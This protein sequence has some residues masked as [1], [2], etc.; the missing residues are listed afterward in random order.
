MTISDLFDQARKA[1]ARAATSSPEPATS[2]PQTEIEGAAR[3]GRVRAMVASD[4]PS[5]KISARILRARDA[6][7][8]DWR[9]AW[10]W[11]ARSINVR[12]LWDNRVPD[13]ESVA[14]ASRPLQVLWVVYNHVVLAVQVALLL[15]AWLL[16]H[17]GRLLYLAPI[18]VTVAAL[19]L[20]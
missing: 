20:T 11:D 12:G 19:W 18:A 10:L 4:V 14:A 13:L 6:I 15:A 17:P 9:Y 1:P 8:D 7:A 16:G 2:G 5:G 3:R